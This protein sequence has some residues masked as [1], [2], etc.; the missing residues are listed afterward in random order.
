ML[1][2][3]NK[4]ARRTPTPLHCYLMV[5]VKQWFSWVTAQLDLFC[6]QK[7]S[8]GCC[9]QKTSF[10]DGSPTWVL[11]EGLSSLPH[12]PPQGT[13]WVSSHDNCCFPHPCSISP[14]SKQKRKQK[15]P[16]RTVLGVLK[17]NVVNSS[18]NYAMKKTAHS[19]SLGGI[20]FHFEVVSI[21]ELVNVF[22]N[23]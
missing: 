7:V 16:S 1:L 19:H 10:Q 14:A 21:K 5:P 8:W 12:R 22:L 13:A 9:H 18:T 23:Y 3:C 6:T 2:L 4:S 17:E 15:K 11:T 20:W